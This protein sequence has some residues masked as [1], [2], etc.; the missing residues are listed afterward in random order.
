[1]WSLQAVLEGN[2]LQQLRGADPAIVAW[3]GLGGAGAEGAEARASWLASCGADME[4]CGMAGVCA[5]VQRIWQAADTGGRATDPGTLP[6]QAIAAR[7]S[8]SAP[9]SPRR[10]PPARRAAHRTANQRR[11]GRIYRAPADWAARVAAA[12]DAGV[13]DVAAA[14]AAAAA[15]AGGGEAEEAEEGADE[16]RRFLRS[17]GAYLA[18]GSAERAAAAARAAS[19]L[20]PWALLARDALLLDA[21]RRFAEGNAAELRTIAALA[22]PALFAALRPSLTPPPPCEAAGE[23]GAGGAPGGELQEWRAAARERWV[24][25][26]DEE[27]GWELGEPVARLWRGARGEAVWAGV[28]CNSAEVA[29]RLLGVLASL[30]TEVGLSSLAHSGPTAAGLG[31]GARALWVD[32]EGSEEADDSL[33]WSSEGMSAELAAENR[34]AKA[35]AREAGAPGGAGGAGGAEGE[36]GAARKQASAAAGGREWE[37]EP[38]PW[39]ESSSDH[40]PRFA[41]PTRAIS[42]AAAERRLRRVPPRAAEAEWWPG[43]QSTGHL[44]RAVRRVSGLCG[45]RGAGAGPPVSGGGGG[46]S[47]SAAG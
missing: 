7:R 35:L 14:A 10:V 9:P 15:A 29:R 4:R 33:E 6:L 1:M 22:H 16:A 40:W 20:D 18:G 47:F 41:G 26:W 34:A 39:M 21:P 45:A 36:E 24:L 42:V 27:C 2:A 37:G 44:H 28:D 17:A 46:G 38:P 32:S 12:V 3:L 8:A 11:V 43:G 13:G 30:E 31:G 23:G 25:E 5:A 19:G